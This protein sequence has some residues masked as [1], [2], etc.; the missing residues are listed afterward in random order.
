MFT[1][2]K[3]FF[4]TVTVE[5]DIIKT[6]LNLHKMPL[7]NPFLMR[8]SSKTDANYKPP[9]RIGRGLTLLSNH[10]VGSQL[11]DFITTQLLLFRVCLGLL[12]LST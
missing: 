1:S 12:N 8:K 2:V 4:A 3:I 9:L 6:M 7:N 11:Y 10:D 5:L